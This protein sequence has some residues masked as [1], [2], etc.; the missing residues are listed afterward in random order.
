MLNTCIIIME[1]NIT[2]SLNL[3][4][5]LFSFSE[6]SAWELL[7]VGGGGGGK[8]LLLMLDQRLFQKRLV[9][10][11]LFSLDFLYVGVISTCCM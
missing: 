9:L 3:L 10:S 1:R 6:M 8:G 11:P 2:L 5:W 7:L 4:L